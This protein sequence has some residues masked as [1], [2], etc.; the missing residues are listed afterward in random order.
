MA[1][2]KQESTF[3]RLTSGQLSRKRRKEI[4]RKIEAEDPALDVVYRNVGGIDVGNQS[5]MVSVPPQ[6][7]RQPIREFGS[8]TQVFIT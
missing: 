7:D 5:H 2:R 3:E 8:W 4:I 6:R 1:K